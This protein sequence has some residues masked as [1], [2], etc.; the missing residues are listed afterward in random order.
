MISHPDMSEGAAVGALVSQSGAAAR[1][2]A[3]GGA[4]TDQ[5]VELDRRGYDLDLSD[6]L[7]AD[8]A[9]GFE[10]EADAPLTRAAVVGFALSRITPPAGVVR[11]RLLASA[12]D[13]EMCALD[14]AGGTV[15]IWTVRGGG[16]GYPTSVS[17]Q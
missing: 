3:G 13:A 6:R 5:P 9:A 11:W 4:I 16:D 1:R 2:L 12:A 17:K 7:T 8:Y 14:A 15:G 10:I